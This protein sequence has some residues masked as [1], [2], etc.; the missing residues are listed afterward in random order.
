MKKKIIVYDK[1]KN[2]VEKTINYLPVRYTISILLSI[3]WILVILFGVVFLS[4]KFIIFSFLSIALQIIVVIS[5]VCSND[6]P[7][8]K[9][10]WLLIV[11]VLPVIG[12]MCY[13][14][15]YRRKLSKKYVRTLN[16]LSNTLSFDDTKTLDLID[17]ELIKSQIKAL[18]KNSNCH[19][20]T[21]PYLPIVID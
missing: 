7:D 5:I 13:F 10:P 18:K 20:R 11:I 1:N 2:K 15:F 8:Y 6:N 21:F 4:T 19:F 17:N 9:G 14:L 16:D 12:Y 3:F